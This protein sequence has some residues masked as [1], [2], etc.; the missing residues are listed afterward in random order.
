[1]TECK[2]S[3][4]VCIRT[5]QLGR[6]R[7]SRALPGSSPTKKCST[8]WSRRLHRHRTRSLRLFP[9][10]SRSPPPQLEKRKLKLL[11]SFVPVKMGDLDAEKEVIERI[12]KVGDL[13]A[14]LKAPFLV[15][16][17]DQLPAATPSPVALTIQAARR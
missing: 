7:L 17:D 12:R 8:K 3:L 14:E 2:K 9:H 15:L 6:S 16:A 11:G 4:F 1:M 13:L 10:R 5:R